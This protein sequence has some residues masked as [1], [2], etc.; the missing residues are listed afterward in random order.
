MPVDVLYIVT[1]N[2]QART[3]EPFA[4]GNPQ[5]FDAI[6]AAISRVGNAISALEAEGFTVSIKCDAVEI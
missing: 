5:P 1:L 2:I 4:T 6:N 3:V